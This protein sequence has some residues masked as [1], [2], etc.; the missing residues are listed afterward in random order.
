MFRRRRSAQSPV[1]SDEP[2]GDVTD[3]GEELE[4]TAAAD[5][6]A[7]A[8]PRRPRP[9]GPWDVEDAPEDGLSRLDLGGLRLPIPDGMQMQVQ[10]QPDM[11]VPTL[12]DGRSAL[13]VTAFAAPKSSGIWDEVRAEIAE[14]LRSTGGTV[15]EA[16]GPFGPE[17]RAVVSVDVPGQGKVRQHVRFIGVDG[18]RW[19][20]RGVLS[21]H[22]ATDSTAAAALELAFRGVIVVR[23]DDAMAPRDPLPMRL[24]KEAME[25]AG[26]EPAQQPDLNPFERGPEITETR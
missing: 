15:E 11:A 13:E 14:S 23:G 21:G 1:E 26:L 25:A 17:L 19:F 12:M 10:V 6:T 9:S 5:D 7:L 8:A 20:C 24:P 18:P 22:A 4:A 2:K 16:S 3:T